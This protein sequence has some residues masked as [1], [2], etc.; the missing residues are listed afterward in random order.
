V[1]ELFDYIVNQ[2]ASEKLYP[3]GMRDKGRGPVIL[4]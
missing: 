4:I 1:W 2:E 3:N